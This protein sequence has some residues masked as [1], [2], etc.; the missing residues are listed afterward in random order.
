MASHILYLNYFKDCLTS[1]ILS[2]TSC[3]RNK[4]R[5]NNSVSAGSPNHAGNKIP[6]SGYRIKLSDKL[7]II[8]VDSMFLP[9]LD[10]SL[11]DEKIT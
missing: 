4:A 6:F 9:S 2:L 1:G 3:F 7:S 10:I 11:K 5:Y 8:I